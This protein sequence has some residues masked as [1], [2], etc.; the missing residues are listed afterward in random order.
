LRDLVKM[1]VV[2]TVICGASGFVLSYVNDATK[3]PREYQ[4]LKYVQEPSIKAVLPSYDNDPIKDRVIVPAGKN[5]KGE[6]VEQTIFPAKEGAKVVAIAYA[7]AATGYNGPIDV[8]VG[9]DP[10]GKL[11]GVSVMTHT[12]TP[13]LGARV[14]ETP[15]TQQFAGLGLAGEL[16]LS[17]QGG[18]INAV[19]GATVSSKATVAA[20]RKALE[21]FPEL[22]KE[23]F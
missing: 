11:T 10:E 23:V 3:A 12:E 4:L 16:N 8:M 7:A 5:E 22:K 20:V 6:P 9:I 21:A 2:L 1:V 13:G 15:F 14:V 17:A 18:Q 19:S